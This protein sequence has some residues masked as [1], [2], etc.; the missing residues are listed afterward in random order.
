M[1]SWCT[2]QLW[3]FA[4]KPR[5]IL[6]SLAVC[7]RMIPT[8][9]PNSHHRRH[10]YIQ[11]LRKDHSGPEGRLGF[12]FFFLYV[13]SMLIQITIKQQFYCCHGAFINFNNKLKDLHGMKS[14]LLNQKVLS[15]GYVFLLFCHPEH[16]S[17]F[18]STVRPRKKNKQSS[19]RQ[20]SSKNKSKKSSS[21]Q[22]SKQ[23]TGPNSPADIDELV[24]NHA[25]TS[26]LTNVNY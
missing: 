11:T 25:H 17:L 21:S 12:S 5:V 3:A 14:Y 6:S 20:K 18:L 13:C 2:A 19:S 26:Y 1:L 24:R 10:I 7:G 9:S 15:T 23:R 22:S 8:V 16:L 4:L